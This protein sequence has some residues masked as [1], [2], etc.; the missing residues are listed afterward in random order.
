MNT[1]DATCVLSRQRGHGRHTV[2]AECRE[3][4]KVGLNPRPAA[5]VGAGDGKN[6]WN[7]HWR[8][9]VVSILLCGSGLVFSSQYPTTWLQ[10]MKSATNIQACG[11]A[12]PPAGTNNNRPRKM[13]N[14]KF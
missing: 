13:L 10:P 5:R 6:V 8:P 3:G 7:Q 14:A 1:R 12:K 9:V 4:F 11:H 2:A